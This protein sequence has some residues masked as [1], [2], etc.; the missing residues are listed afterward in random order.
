MMDDFWM[1]VLRIASVDV[2]TVTGGSGII[3]VYVGNRQAGHVRI[4]KHGDQLAVTVPGGAKQDHLIQT[5]WIKRN[6]VTRFVCPKCRQPRDRL[7]LTHASNR[8]SASAFECR[9]CAHK[10]MERLKTKRLVA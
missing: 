6:S 10:T 3:P 7:Y 4:E 9:G 1:S 8:A 2:A 5:K